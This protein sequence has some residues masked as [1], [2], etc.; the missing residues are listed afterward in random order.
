MMTMTT[1]WMLMKTML[2]LSNSI[3]EGMHGMP[4]KEGGVEGGEDREV[5]R[6]AFQMGEGAWVKGGDMIPAGA[7]AEL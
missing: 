4:S 6:E 2:K 3:L 1:K 5:E 7:V